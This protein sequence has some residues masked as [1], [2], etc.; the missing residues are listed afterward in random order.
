MKLDTP[1]VRGLR[2][3]LVDLSVQ[4]IRPHHGGSK[5]DAA[6]PEERAI[7]ERF[8]PFAELFVLVAYADGRFEESERSVILG[9][10]RAM[11]GG[12]VRT[13]SLEALKDVL[14]TTVSQS[15][16]DERLEQICG[17]LAFDRE[18]AE[19]AFALASAVALSDN[20][21]T[22]EEADLLAKVA[23]WL[24]LSENRIDRLLNAGRMSLDPRAP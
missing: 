19:L 18:D 9:A 4:S 8:R 1:L 15:D 6:S 12:R 7:L 17:A 20:R 22:T 2:D 14:Q 11:T 16:P 21:T 3:H 23:S 13:P 10:F 24:R 5:A